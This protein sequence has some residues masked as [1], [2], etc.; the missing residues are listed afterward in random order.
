[1]A[2]REKDEQKQDNGAAA[3]WLNTAFREETTSVWIR[4][5]QDHEL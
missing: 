5:H 2:C 4:L 3:R 1:M